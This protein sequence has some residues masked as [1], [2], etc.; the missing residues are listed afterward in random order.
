MS[1]Y[2]R[3]SKRLLESVAQDAASELLSILA[4]PDF[5]LQKHKLQDVISDEDWR[6]LDKLYTNLYL[7]LKKH[8][9]GGQINEIAGGSDITTIANTL[10]PG[11]IISFRSGEGGRICQVAAPF[12]PEGSIKGKITLID[13][14]PTYSR[15]GGI[16]SHNDQSEQSISI[17][18][19]YTITEF[20]AIENQGRSVKKGDYV[21]DAG[22]KEVQEVIGDGYQIKHKY[23]S[24]PV[25]IYPDTK[26]L[27]PKRVLHKP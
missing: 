15:L 24:D 13:L 14:S 1:I 19:D 26:S 8:E 18:N 7:E 16:I 17:S 10:K 6:A 25:T 12:V 3:V 27:R 9:V 2:D 4:S 23:N 21:N 22:W 5:I 11:M 20:V